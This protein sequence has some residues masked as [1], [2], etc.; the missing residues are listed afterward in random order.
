MIVTKFNNENLE[1]VQSI[2]KGGYFNVALTYVNNK[3]ETVSVKVDE[4]RNTDPEIASIVSDDGDTIMVS[5]L[6]LTDYLTVDAEEEFVRLIGSGDNDSIRKYANA[7]MVKLDPANTTHRGLGKYLEIHSAVLPGLK[8]IYNYCDN[9]DKLHSMDRDDFEDV[10]PNATRDA[11]SVGRHREY[12]EIFISPATLDEILSAIEVN[13]AALAAK[14]NVVMSLDYKL[15]VGHVINVAA[16][17][18]IVADILESYD[19]DPTDGERVARRGSKLI[20]VCG[21]RYSKVD[22]LDYLLEQI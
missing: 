22:M 13:N 9:C 3:A 15:K 7:N 1:F 11:W 4:I 14:A 12:K 16:G 19:I 18:A 2:V 5:N 21:G 6:T 8:G 20:I 10:R 17:Y